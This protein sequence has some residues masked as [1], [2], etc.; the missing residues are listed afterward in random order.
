[1]LGGF[2]GGVWELGNFFRD[3][4]FIGEQVGFIGVIGCWGCLVI[5]DR[6]LE[7]RDFGAFGVVMRMLSVVN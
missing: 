1:M 3:L 7:D 6:R 2:L 4:L 5:G